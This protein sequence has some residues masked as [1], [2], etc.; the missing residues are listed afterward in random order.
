MSLL[1]IPLRFHHSLKQICRSLSLVHLVLWS[2][3]IETGRKNALWV[4]MSGH[5]PALRDLHNLHNLPGSETIEE[6]RQLT[7][8]KVPVRTFQV[9]QHDRRPKPEQP[10]C[11][12]SR[13]RLKVLKIRKAHNALDCC[14]NHICQ[15]M[16]HAQT[17]TAKQK[18]ILCVITLVRQDQDNIKHMAQ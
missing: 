8:W 11:E 6:V 13:K 5:H 10:L 18:P 15:Q 3:S 1:L 14:C 16:R 7:R 9:C 4:K 12:R 17:S 2:T